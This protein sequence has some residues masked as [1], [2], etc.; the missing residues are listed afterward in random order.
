MLPARRRGG[1][2]GTG[3]QSDVVLGQC[4]RRH[5]ARD[6]T[7]IAAVVAVA[8]TGFEPDQSVPEATEYL[9]NRPI[10]GQE[11][12]G[13]DEMAALGWKLAQVGSRS[14]RWRQRSRNWLAVPPEA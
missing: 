10:G 1:V 8:P 5:L 14:I 4:Q 6:Y 2:R 11:G 13:S 9:K 3:P 12:P 7:L